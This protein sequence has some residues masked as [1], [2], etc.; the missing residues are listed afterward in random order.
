VA[1]VE[2]QVRAC[3]AGASAGRRVVVAYE[4]VWAIGSGLTPSVGEIEAVHG[5]VRRALEAVLGTDG[6]GVPILYGG[7]VKVD[8]AAEILG[9]DNVDGVL[10]G[11]ASLKASDF[12]TII[13][14]A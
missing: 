9:A 8:N 12:I 10:V 5:A 11:G 13:Q 6:I 2:R 1:T 3:L 14:A 4:P 7:S